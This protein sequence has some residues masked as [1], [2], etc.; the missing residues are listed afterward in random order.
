MHAYKYINLLI[1][2]FLLCSATVNI[3]GCSDITESLGNT[4]TVIPR[5]YNE[6]YCNYLQN[7]SLVD[8]TVKRYS[9]SDEYYRFE[10]SFFC[11][12]PHVPSF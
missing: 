6:S 7:Q 4:T 11:S 12:N 1:C 8:D 3:P 2:A 10:N 9:P 5:I